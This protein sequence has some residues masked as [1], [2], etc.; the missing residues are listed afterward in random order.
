[1]MEEKN[2]ESFESW[3]VKKKKGIKQKKNSRVDSNRKME[4]FQGIKSSTFRNG[5]I[6]RAVYRRMNN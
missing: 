2:E 3:M 5:N 6:I 1:M 4:D